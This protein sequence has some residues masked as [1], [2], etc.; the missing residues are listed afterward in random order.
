M[1]PISH[2]VLSSVKYAAALAELGFSDLASMLDGEVLTDTILAQRVGMNR[3]EIRK[4]RERID[5]ARSAKNAKKS[6]GEGKR[7]VASMPG[8]TATL[9]LR[10][11]F[12]LNF[13]GPAASASTMH[14]TTGFGGHGIML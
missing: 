12:G 1:T 8:A 5:A 3:V 2:C 14:G 13:M 11:M 6:A 10:T 9:S 4:F 7:D